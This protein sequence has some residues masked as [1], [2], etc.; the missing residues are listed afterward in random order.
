VNIV[1]TGGGTAGHIYPAIN[2]GLYLKENHHATL[3]YIGKKNSMEERIAKENG[4]PFYTTASQGF[5]VKRIVSFAGKNLKGTIEASSLLMKLK[6]DYI[7]STGGYVSGPV[8]AA[9]NLL[10]IPYAI[11]EQNSITGKVNKVFGKHASTV[12][13]SFPIVETKKTCYSGNPVRYNDKLDKNGNSIL[14]FGGS[15]GSQTINDF[16]V[17]F[18]KKYPNINVTLI[19]GEK[20][21]EQTI[22]KGLSNNIK[23]LPF[24]TDMLSVYKEAKVIVARSG[25]GTI[26]EIANLNIPPILIPFPQSAEDHQKKNADFFGNQQAAIVINEKDGFTKEL[27]ESLID[28]YQHQDKIDIMKENLEKLAMRES[29]KLISERV[30]RDIKQPVQ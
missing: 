7:F 2:V 29:A 20:R 12:F 16:G 14:F 13:Y 30:L 4:I 25:S 15:G 10:K 18:A 22:S 19:T 23:V 9:A 11:H 8:I 5:S 26:F 3:F 28:L 6:P 21:Y 17:E 27:E 24:V 1:L